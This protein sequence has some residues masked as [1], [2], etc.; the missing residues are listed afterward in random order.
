MNGMD[1]RYINPFLTA[2]QNIFE[3]MIEVIGCV[4]FSFPESVALQ[5]ASALLDD[6]LTQVNP[7]VAKAGGEKRWPEIDP[8]LPDLHLV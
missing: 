4:V 8:I 7:N 1:V 5:L 2:V 3:T 6:T